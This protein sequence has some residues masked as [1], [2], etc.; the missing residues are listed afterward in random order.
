MLSIN[1]ENTIS[2]LI[3]GAIAFTV[4]HFVA[5]MVGVKPIV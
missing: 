3:I 2:I 5:P 1:L 4:Y